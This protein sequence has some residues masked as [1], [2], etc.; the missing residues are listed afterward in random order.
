MR[1]GRHVRVCLCGRRLTTGALSPA[2]MRSGT[3]GSWRYLLLVGN[4]YEY[5]VQ[6][7]R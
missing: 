2:V 5:T 4:I 1:G 6:R 3:V 7:P